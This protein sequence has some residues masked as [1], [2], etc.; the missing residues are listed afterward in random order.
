[1]AD[2]ENR[3]YDDAEG[4]LDPGLLYTKEFCIGS[5]FEW[6][7]SPPRCGRTRS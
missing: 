7:N 1:M 3:E 6:P 2:R 4:S 5:F